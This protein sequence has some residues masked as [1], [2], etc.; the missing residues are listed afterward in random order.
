MSWRTWNLNLGRHEKASVFVRSLESNHC[1]TTDSARDLM[2]KAAFTTAPDPMTVLLGGITVAELGFAEPT[3]FGEICR[4]VVGSEV[5][6]D[7]KRYV[8][9]LCPSEVGPALREQYLDQPAKEWLRIGMEPIY[10]SMGHRAIFR[11]VHGDDDVLYLDADDGGDD[12][13]MFDDHNTFVFLLR[14]KT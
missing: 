3:E 1:V 12:D 9:E 4:K 13:D 6:I 10:S 14:P 2:T 11:V 8:V 7:D 5:V